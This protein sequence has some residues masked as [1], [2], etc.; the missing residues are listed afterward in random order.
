MRALVDASVLSLSLRRSKNAV[1]NPDQQIL[2]SLLTEMIEDGR[3][4]LIGPIR[5][6]VLSGVREAGHFEKLRTTLA[7]FPDEPL[8]Q[9]H[10]EEA[11]RL[12][13]L[14]RSRGV[15]CGSVDMMICAVASEKRWAILT[16]DAGM[17]RCIAVLQ[18]EGL[19]S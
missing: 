13:N 6:E 8:S 18:S 14:C 5:Q 17:K 3:F 4:V 10:F 2:V 16:A 12:F 9:S 19:L 1:L 15:S 7:A 11:A